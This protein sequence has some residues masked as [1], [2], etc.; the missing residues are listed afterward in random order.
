M[1]PE[2]RCTLAPDCT[3]PPHAPEA[4][5][6]GKRHIPGSPCDYCGKATPDV[7]GPC[8]DCWSPISVADFRALMAAEGIDTVVTS[9][10]ERAH[11]S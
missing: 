9:G 5:P 7:G 8:P 10:K 4:H 1:T 11:D 2:E 3:F 6:C